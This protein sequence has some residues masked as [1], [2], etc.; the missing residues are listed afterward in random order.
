MIASFAMFMACKDDKK[1]NESNDSKNG[2]YTGL[3]KVSENTEDEFEK[4][5]VEVETEIVGETLTLKL[6][7]AQF[8][9]EMPVEISMLVEGIELTKKD[10]GYTLSGD[11][12]TP[13]SIDGSA[14]LIPG[15]Q[16][17]NLTGTQTKDKLELSMSVNISMYPE[18]IP[19]SYSGA[20]KK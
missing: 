13:K 7:K 14:F 11:G 6:L 1:E 5:G 4:S 15:T 3:L 19:V 17:N 9:A 2:K 18:P 20:T 8:S 16:I 10:E 12:L